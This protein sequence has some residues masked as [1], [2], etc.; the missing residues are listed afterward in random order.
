M[1]VTLRNSDHNKWGVYWQSS[2]V[3]RGYYVRTGL[4]WREYQPS[5]NVW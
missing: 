1:T 3:I 5:P 4:E 2:G